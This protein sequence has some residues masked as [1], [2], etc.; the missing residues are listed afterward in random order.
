MAGPGQMY[1]LQARKQIAVLQW[2]GPDITIEIKYCPAHKG[3]PGN[4][5]CDEWAKLTAEEPAARGEEWLGYSNRTGART[6]PLPRFL[7]HFKR[8]I[9]EKKW[10]ENRHCSVLVVLMSDAD[11]G[12][13]LRGAPPV[14]CPAE[15][16]VGRDAEREES[17]AGDLRHRL[18]TW[19]LLVNGKCSQARGTRLALDYGCGKAGPG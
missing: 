18:K 3:V 16:P 8:E 4:E 13:S 5:K 7:S 12:S 17:G 2:A 10:A 1:A 9:T 14:K 11:A 19:D 15:D 6:I